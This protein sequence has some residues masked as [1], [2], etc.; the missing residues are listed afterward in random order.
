MVRCFWLLAFK[1]IWLLLRHWQS[2]M[3]IRVAPSLA[4]F[5]MASKPL[6]VV[7]LLNMQLFIKKSSNNC[8][9]K[10]KYAVIHLPWVARLNHARVHFHDASVCV[11]LL[12]KPCELK[13]MKG[14]DRWHDI[15]WIASLVFAVL[16][17]KDLSSFEQHNAFG[18]GSGDIKNVDPTFFSTNLF[19]HHFCDS[20]ILCMRNVQSIFFSDF[21]S[22][23]LV[24]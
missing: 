14:L 1:S 11:C 6:L 12:P 20:I 9:C 13:E 15:H 5:W 17:W 16:T 8:S 3:E 24:T 19:T 10:C 23:F 18:Q 7:W 22:T 21:D 4:I 2:H